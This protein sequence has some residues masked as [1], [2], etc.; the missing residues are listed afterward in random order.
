MFPGWKLPLGFDSIPESLQ[1]WLDAPKA[2]E[3][4]SS[5]YG[6]WLVD[7][8]TETYVD[9][10]STM[11]LHADLRWLQGAEQSPFPDDV[12]HER[13]VDFDQL[14]AEI[15]KRAVRPESAPRRTTLSCFELCSTRGSYSSSDANFKIVSVVRNRFSGSVGDSRKFLT[16]AR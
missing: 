1:L 13:S 15:A 12:M 16:C 2:N 6:A 3:Q 10:W 5:P 8:L 11:S 14:V 4:P 7:R 9:D